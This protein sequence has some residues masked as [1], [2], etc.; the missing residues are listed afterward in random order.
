MPSDLATSSARRAIPCRVTHR[1]PHALIGLVAWVS[2]A[3]FA[4]PL[5]SPAPLTQPA[6]LSPADV[7]GRVAKAFHAGPTA[8]HV[9]IKVSSSTGRERTSRVE[10]LTDPGGNDRPKRVVLKLGRVLHVEAAGSQFRAVS[11]RNDQAAYASDLPAEFDPAAIESR[12]PPLP[13]PHV[14]WVFGPTWI[15]EE[16]RPGE[17]LL[18]PLGWVRAESVDLEDA[19]RECV[20]RGHTLAGPVRVVVDAR[21]WT[22]RSV[23]GMLPETDLTLELTCRDADPAGAGWAVNVADRQMV[24]S[25]ADLRPLPAELQPG[26]P[27]TALGLMNPDLSPFSTIDAMKS[28]GAEPT[29]AGEGPLLGVL[30]LYREGVPG[31]ED[32]AFLAV[33]SMRSL[34][35]NLD[36]RRL[37]SDRS[38][39]RLFIQPVAVFDVAGFSPAAARGA[40][41]KWDAAQEKAVWTSAGQALMDRFER[42]TPALAVVVDS[43][44]TLLGVAGIEIGVNAAEATLA[45]VRAIIEEHSAPR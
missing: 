31:A 10:V 15:G 8:Q 5:A 41:S 42:G 13:I 40:A 23:R 38:T 9:S 4:T 1:V 17:F 32:A 14:A 35:K 12:L 11:P 36:R 2:P 30:V 34:K 29:E 27:V 28:Q 37:T 44:M 20:V 22:L 7:L 19:R 3:S 26:A 45:E 39:P 24:A 16:N 25:I 21:T 6:T 33:G 18:P 43:E